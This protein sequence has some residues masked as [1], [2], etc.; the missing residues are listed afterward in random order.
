VVTFGKRVG[1]YP[2]PPEPEGRF[3]KKSEAKQLLAQGGWT[4][5]LEYTSTGIDGYV[6]ERGELL[7]FMTRGQSV[8]YESRKAVFEYGK[9]VRTLPSTHVLEGLL[10]QGPHFIEAVPSLIDELA[11]HLKLPRES[12]DGTWETLRLIDAALKKIRPRRRI[13]ETPNLFAGIVAYCG[14]VLRRHSGGSWVLHE[15]AGGIHE[16]YINTAHHF[17]NPFLEPYK[18]ILE[19]KRGGVSIAGVIAGELMIAGIGGFD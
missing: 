8:L 12:L 4:P 15:V 14:E 17:L 10:P 3:V 7:L 6:S 2:E 13:F 5:D 19:Y 1:A 16:P 9:W 11:Q 18:E